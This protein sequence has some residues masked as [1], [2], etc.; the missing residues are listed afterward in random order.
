MPRTKAGRRAS[1]EAHLKAEA[2]GAGAEAKRPHFAL[3]LLA[4]SGKWLADLPV[5]EPLMPLG[6]STA[7]PKTEGKGVAK[8]DK[9][10]LAE[11]QI[12]EWR[13]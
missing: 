11:A 7:V 3:S 9:R 6:R 1:L 8:D 5:E 2:E 10:A 12:A 4:E 13:D